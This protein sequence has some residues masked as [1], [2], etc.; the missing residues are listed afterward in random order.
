MQNGEKDF[1]CFSSYKTLVKTIQNLEENDNCKA[2]IKDSLVYHAR[3]DDDIINTIGTINQSWKDAKMVATSPINTIACSY[4]VQN[5]FHKVF[6]NVMPTSCVRDTFQTQMRVRHLNKNEMVFCLPEPK[7][8][9]FF[10]SLNQV[11]FTVLADYIDFNKDK[12]IY[13]MDLINSIIK[14]CKSVNPADECYDLLA[15]RMSYDET[16]MPEALREILFFNLYEQVMSRQFYKEMF[17]RFFEN[18]WL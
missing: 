11:Y 7:Q 13:M 12:K 4:S 2:I 6:V 15:I 8:L 17:Y 14:Q 9:Q 10:K 5:D 18:M 16:E 1:L 3:T